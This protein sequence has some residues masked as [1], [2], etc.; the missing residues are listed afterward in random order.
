MNKRIISL[1]LMSLSLIS[2]LIFLGCSAFGLSTDLNSM[3]NIPLMV[4]TVNILM[5]GITSF[6]LSF[7]FLLLSLFFFRHRLF[8]LAIG[9]FGI[10]LYQLWPIFKA[11]NVIFTMFNCSKHYHDGCIV[12][13]REYQ[14][15]DF[16]VLEVN[17]ILVGV[18]IVMILLTQ[19]LLIKVIRS[20]KQLVI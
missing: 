1:I 5:I 18:G 6:F 17:I 8:L 16:N 2:F 4:N 20:K 3:S 19:L 7:L 9:G 10:L 11:A 15:L 14:Q 12:N 13:L